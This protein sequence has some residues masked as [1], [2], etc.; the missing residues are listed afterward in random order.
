[1]MGPGETPKNCR[2]AVSASADQPIQEYRPKC[3]WCGDY[4]PEKAY[5]KE[6]GFKFCSYHCSEDHDD[7]LRIVDLIAWR[8]KVNRALG[9]KDE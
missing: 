9:G 2:C 1:M 6:G 7:H 8:D 5:A 3:D 4:L